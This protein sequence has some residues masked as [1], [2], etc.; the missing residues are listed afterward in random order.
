[1]PSDLEQ[2]G[3]G[4]FRDAL[5]SAV[6]RRLDADCPGKK[7][8]SAKSKNLN[9]TPVEEVGDTRDD[10]EVLNEFVEVLFAPL[11]LISCRNS[12]SN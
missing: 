4:A 5:S 7:K 11:N 8:R 10:L 3:F 2:S 1:M 12:R 9:I 6:I